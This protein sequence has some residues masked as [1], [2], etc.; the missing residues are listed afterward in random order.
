MASKKPKSNVTIVTKEVAWSDDQ[1]TKYQV[2]AEMTCE[3]GRV[4]RILGDPRKTKE[5]AFNSFYEEFALWK[6]FMNEI[7]KEIAGDE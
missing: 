7:D 4:V 5:G 2:C 1:P 3:K 6:T